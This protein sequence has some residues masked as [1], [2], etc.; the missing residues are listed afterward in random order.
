MDATTVI[1]GVRAGADEGV[2]LGPAIPAG[3]S[4]AQ[5]G[6]EERTWR[7]DTTKATMVSGDANWLTST[8][9]RMSASINDAPRV[10]MQSDA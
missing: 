10:C 3:C 2:S 9:E 8:R 4:H 1:V 5:R 7:T 6:R